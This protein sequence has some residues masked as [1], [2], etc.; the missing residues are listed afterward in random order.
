MILEALTMQ[1]ISYRCS[2]CDHVNLTYILGKGEAERLVVE[3]PVQRKRIFST[4]HDANHFGI[5]RTNDMVASKYYWPGLS[6]EVRSYVS[7]VNN[8]AT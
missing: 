1:Y 5:N 6:A 3:D 2:C 4:V 7:T 8:G